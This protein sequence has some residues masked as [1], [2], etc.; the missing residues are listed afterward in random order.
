MMH[1]WRQREAEVKIGAE[2]DFS[3]ENLGTCLECTHEEPKR[4]HRAATNCIREGENLM[5]DD[6]M[7]TAG[8]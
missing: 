6:K 1:T 3:D 2:V 7:M 8:G 5:T 4:R